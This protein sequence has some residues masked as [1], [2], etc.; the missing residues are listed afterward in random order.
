MFI[1]LE[2]IESIEHSLYQTTL[3]KER[4]VLNKGKS[5]KFN[6]ANPTEKALFEYA[7]SKGNFSK[8]V[9]DL[10]LR[11]KRRS[12][13]TYRANAEGIIKIRF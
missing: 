12:Q 11:E 10:L 9:K 13:T 8:F 1:F 3:I 5:I 6:L 4:I 7:N 2:L